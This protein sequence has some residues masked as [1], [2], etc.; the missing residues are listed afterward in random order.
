MD[1]YEFLYRLRGMLD[2]V[3]AAQ[4][5]ST[6]LPG[7]VSLTFQIAFSPQKKPRSYATFLGYIHLAWHA[8]RAFWYQSSTT[9]C[10]CVWATYL[11]TVCN[12]FKATRCLNLNAACPFDFRCS[13]T[14]SFL[15]CRFGI[16]PFRS[17]LVI[18][19]FSRNL[20]YRRH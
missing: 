13:R 6:L 12:E 5:A 16:P 7:C 4:S 18:M 20:S 15:D 3:S 19:Q 17:W 2:E 14:T 9:K 1:P 11:D 10:P 8:V